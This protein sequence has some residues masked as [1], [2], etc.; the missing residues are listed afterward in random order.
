MVKAKVEV[1]VEDYGVAV[2]RGENGG[3]NTGCQ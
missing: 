2:K 3:K 1:V